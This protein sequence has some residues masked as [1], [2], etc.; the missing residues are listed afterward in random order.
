MPGTRDVKQPQGNTSAA[1]LVE[2]LWFI[3]SAGA[4][5]GLDNLS[6]FELI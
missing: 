6:S 3:D 5:P 1:E 2:G 4:S